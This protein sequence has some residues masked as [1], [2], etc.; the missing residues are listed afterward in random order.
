M[1]TCFRNNLV[2]AA[3]S[4]LLSVALV[5]CCP[6]SVPRPTPTI[7]P[8]PPPSSS[9]TP[10]TAYLPGV[11]SG[12]PA[13]TPSPVPP[14]PKPTPSQPTPLPPPVPKPGYGV[15]IHLFAGDVADTLEWARGLG[16][17]WVKQQ[18]EWH[19]IEHGPDNFD[20]GALDQAV[21]ASNA[22]GFKLLLGVTHAPD[23]TRATTLESGPPADYA[24]FGRF[25]G[26]LATRYKGRVAAYELW[27]EPNLGREW[28]GDTLD[29]ARFVALVAQGAAAVRAADPDAVIISG[30]PAVTGINDGVEATDDRV[31][32]RGMY[33]AGIAQ[34]V[35]GIG[36]H[37]YG[38]ANPP[39]ES[40]Q[41]AEHVASSHNEHSSFFFYDT[42]EDYHAIMLEYGD[43]D[44]QIWVT[45]FGWP[46]VENMGEM[47]TM[48]WEYGREVSEEQQA[49]YIVRAYRM[50]E[51]RPWVGRMF[52]WNLNIA[53]I[54][55]EGNPTSAYSLLRPDES[56]RPAYIALR[57][58]EPLESQ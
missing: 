6:F 1:S 23:W 2:W 44:R 11:S 38:F 52:L 58:A 10:Y 50:G 42:L 16:V 37:P 47:D 5:G 32:L 49:E 4:V 8:V 51:E 14:T 46:S 40:W 53:P 7:S 33:A 54:W 22:F 19:T 43:A 41:D 29:P 21:E 31:F 12:A 24:Q 27:N 57:L 13:T 56:Y 34:W 36:A 15:Q 55:G 3:L 25:M 48:G 18:V 17:G 26:Q 30:A 9:A 39:D 20:W 28:R 45:E 35:D